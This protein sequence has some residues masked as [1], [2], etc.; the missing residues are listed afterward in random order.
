[1]TQVLFEFTLPATIKKKAKYWLSSCPALD[2]FAQGQTEEEAKTNLETTVRLFLQSCYER[3]TLQQALNDCG[4]ALNH[5]SKRFRTH[6]SLSTIKVP[7][8][9]LASGKCHSECR[10]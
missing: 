5:T 10:V 2:L 7:L 3:G 4:F 8:Y 6:K 9:L 1:M